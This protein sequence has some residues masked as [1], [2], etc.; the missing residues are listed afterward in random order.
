MD[1]TTTTGRPTLR[2]ELIPE[3]TRRDIGQATLDGLMSYKRY[4]EKHP[5]KK[6]EFEAR[7]AEIRK[8][9]P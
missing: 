4:L 5:D 7:C 1:A 2:L 6:R 3:H 9:Y 8:R